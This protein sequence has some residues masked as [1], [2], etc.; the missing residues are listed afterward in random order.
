M[1]KKKR[2]KYSLAV[3]TVL[4]AKKTDLF[5]LEKLIGYLRYSTNIIPIGNLFI[6]PLEIL[7]AKIRRDID[8]KKASKYKKYTFN[9]ELIF[10]L[11]TWKGIY[12]QL[13]NNPVPIINLLHPDKKKIITIWTDASANLTKGIGGFD[14]LGNWYAFNSQ[15]N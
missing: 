9:R 15:F 5:H 4:N 12:K 6:H 1:T 13:Q 7:A 8:Q 2:D 11:L 10:C 3:Q 14:T